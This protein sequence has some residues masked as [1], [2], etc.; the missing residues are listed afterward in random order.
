MKKVSSN[1]LLEKF[2][3]YVGNPTYNKFTGIYNGSC[4][5]CREGKSWLK[6]KRLFHYPDTGT[7]YC[8]NCSKSWNSYSWLGEVAG[9]TKEEIDLHSDSDEVV[10]KEIFLD[11][12]PLYKRSNNSLPHDSINLLDKRQQDFYRSN[13]TFIKAVE[14]L[15]KRKLDL[16][17]NKSPSYFISFTDFIHKN[18]ICIPYYDDNKIVFYQTRSIDGTEP[19]YLNKIGCDKTLF[20]IERVDSSIDYI[21]LFEGPLDASM[22]KNGVSVA[23]LTLTEKQQK[24]LLKFPFHKKIW[25]IDNPAYDQAAKKNTINLLERGNSVFNW[26]NIPYKDFNEWCVKENTSEIPFDVILN[27]LY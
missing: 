13:S 10:K 5:V 24:Q 2:Y 12:E 19:R 25:I 27:N 1:L 22:V 26:K 4:P 20:G 8:F 21:F 9:M 7:F 15:K 18:R 16:A 14:Y 6:K 11:E 3:T 23:G 17:I